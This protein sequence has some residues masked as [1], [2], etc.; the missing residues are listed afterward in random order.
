MNSFCHSALGNT[1]LGKD[2]KRLCT[3]LTLFDQKFIS[4]ASLTKGVEL[5]SRAPTKGF[6]IS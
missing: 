1:V 5:V 6:K 4:I 2:H 3:G